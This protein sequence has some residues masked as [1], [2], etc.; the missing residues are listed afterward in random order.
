MAPQL[1]SKSSSARRF[2]WY[3]QRRGRGGS[4]GF[5]LCA[6]FLFPS[7][8]SRAGGHLSRRHPARGARARGKAC[9]DA[10]AAGAW[11]GAG[12]RDGRGLSEFVALSTAPP[13][14]LVLCRTPTPPAAAGVLSCWS[15]PRS[16]RVP[17]PP[18]RVRA[19]RRTSDGNSVSM[20]LL[21]A[22]KRFH[23]FAVLGFGSEPPNWIMGARNYVF[24][25][26]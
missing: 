9:G 7:P 2:S 14:E 10:A 26:F 11:E 24:L 20:C 3:R 5:A 13:P 6:R 25:W 18:C 22:S 4:R 15:C 21:T 17:P 8:S 1:S 23:S 12:T 19:Q 16:P